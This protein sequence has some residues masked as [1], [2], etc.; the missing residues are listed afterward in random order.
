MWAASTDFQ[1]VFRGGSPSNTDAVL[2]SPRDAPLIN[3]PLQRGDEAHGVASNRFN[4]FGL[5]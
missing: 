1:G 5:R 4:G 3:T 2:R